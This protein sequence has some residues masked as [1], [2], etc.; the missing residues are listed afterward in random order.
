MNLRHIDVFEGKYVSIN[1]SILT[2]TEKGEGYIS[3]KGIFVD[4]DEDAIYLG[5]TASEITSFILWTNVVSVDLDTPDSE[6]LE[7][8]TPSGVNN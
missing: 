5:P 2:S 4:Y 7:L 8:P 6:F 3:Y 1:T